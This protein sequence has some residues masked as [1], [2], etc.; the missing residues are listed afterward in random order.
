MTI[1]SIGATLWLLTSLAFILD[2]V[3]APRR[4]IQAGLAL[5]GLEFAFV[6]LAFSQARCEGGPCTGDEGL[7]GASQT[8][9]MYVAPAIAAAFT[10]CLIVYGLMRHRHASR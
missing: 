2:S 6:V 9:V 7:A 8:I 4:L 10:L 3:K 1:V 5:L